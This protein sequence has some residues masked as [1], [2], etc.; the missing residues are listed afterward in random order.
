MTSPARNGRECRVLRQVVDN[1]GL[2]GQSLQ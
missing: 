2:L 1:R